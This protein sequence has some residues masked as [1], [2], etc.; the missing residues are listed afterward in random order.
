M[1]KKSDYSKKQI[2]TAL[3]QLLQNQLIE[4]ISITKLTKQAKVSRNAFYNNFDSIEAVL[5]E[6]YRQAHYEA[7]A[8]KLSRNDYFQSQESKI[9]LI[10]LIL[11]P[12]CF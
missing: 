11:I 5:K 8:N 9:S 2:T 10:F 1:S 7:F 3:I 12:H 6:T 4:D